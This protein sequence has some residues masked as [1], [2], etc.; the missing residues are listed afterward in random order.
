[1]NLYVVR[2]LETPSQITE[3]SHAEAYAHSVWVK[4]ATLLAAQV[5]LG[6]FDSAEQ[7]GCLYSCGLERNQL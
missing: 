5:N 7:K 1:M 6:C 2:R 3:V 4:C